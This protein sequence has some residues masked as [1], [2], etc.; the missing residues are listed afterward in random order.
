MS[1]YRINAGII[2][3]VVGNL[4]SH[5]MTPDYK[6][7]SDNSIYK[8]KTFG[9]M[10]FLPDFNSIEILRKAQPMD[11]INC[12]PIASR[13]IVISDKFLSILEISRLPAEIEVFDV[14][15]IHKGNNYHYNY[16]YLYKSWHLE[17]IDFE[18]MQFFETNSIG[19]VIKEIE[20]NTVEQYNLKVD[21]YSFRKIRPKEIFLKN[22]L[23][24]YDIFRLSFIGSGYYVSKKLKN[25]ILSQDCQGIEFT[26]LSDIRTLL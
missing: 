18:K 8:L 21:Q 15:A 23:V 1:Y 13:G 10:G 3:D 7:G 17:Y 20:I 19:T 4:A 14:N 25:Y 9:K 22:S 6:Y 12:V 16:F 11:I 24:E 5:H 2:N 26:E